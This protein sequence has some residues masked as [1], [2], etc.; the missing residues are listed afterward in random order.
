MAKQILT[1]DELKESSRFMLVKAV[2]S[3]EPINLRGKVSTYWHVTGSQV[4][5]LKLYVFMDEQ[6]I[7][8]ESDVSDPI[9][10]PFANNPYFTP[11]T[12][13]EIAEMN[14]KKANT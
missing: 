5:G 14:P 13:K 9:V 7:L 6:L 12:K 11:F 10:F 3:A 2:K 1:I 4:A 8:I